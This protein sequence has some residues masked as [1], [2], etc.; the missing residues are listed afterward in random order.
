MSRTFVGQAV[1]GQPEGV[2]AESIGFNNLGSGLQV[3]VMNGANQIG[4]R[5]IQFVVAAVDEDALGVKQRSHR[6][7]A[8]NG[9]LLDP[10]KKVVCHK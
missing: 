5:E 3:I 7:I 8:E 9:R 1:P 10:C 6:A 4:L 2:G